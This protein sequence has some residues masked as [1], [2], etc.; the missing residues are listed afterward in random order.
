M[1]TALTSADNEIIS[2]HINA[3][4]RDGMR[5]FAAREGLINRIT[6]QQL[7]ND[8]ADYSALV[9]VNADIDLA[10]SQLDAIRE[11]A[12]DL[13]GADVV[14]EIER[15]AHVM[16]EDPRQHLTNGITVHGVKIDLRDLP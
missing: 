14:E 2:R 1:K 11:L 15:A 6:Q 9:A 5:S 12:V 4:V 7:S 8:S 3:I 16:W 13:V 10:C